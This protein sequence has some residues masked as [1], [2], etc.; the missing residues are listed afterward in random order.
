MSNPEMTERLTQTVQQGA[1]VVQIENETQR[2]IA[3]QQPRDEEKVREAALKE[4]ELYPQ[5]AAKAYYV[6]PYK[7]GDK[8]VNVEGPSI[9]AAMA[10][11]RRWGNSANGARIV[12]EDNNR[13]QL[14]GVF[15]DYET[16][17]RTVRPISVSKQGWSKKFG[18]VI[19]LRDDRLNM[20]IQAGA[21][22]A[23]RNAILSALPVGLVEE[24]TATAKKVAA[25]GKTGKT[26]PVVPLKERME[27][28]YAKFA[29]IGAPKTHVDAY[30]AEHH[31][32][33]NDEMVL[34]HMIGIYNAIEDGQAKLEEVFA[35][36]EKAAPAEPQKAAP[37]NE[38]MIDMGE[39]KYIMELLKKHKVSIEALNGFLF[40]TYGFRGTD[41]ISKAIYGAVCSWIAGDTQEIPFGS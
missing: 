5:F 41:S 2:T 19:P 4:L 8:T 9:K 6:I 20:A 23:V 17:F 12:G 18:K 39:R 10:L 30:L 21:S 16:N 38:P 1:T 11:G 33:E 14:E 22:K 25:S 31:E 15:L 35:T 29:D 36:L 7:D 32:L 28:M 26:A 34:A 24:Y 37:G 27:K 40:N 3:I 13:I